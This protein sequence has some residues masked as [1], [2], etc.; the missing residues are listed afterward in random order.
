MVFGQS[1]TFTATVTSSGPAPTGTVTFL[2]G[3]TPIGTSSVSGGIATFSIDT[4]AVGTHAIFAVYNGDSNNN[5]AT[6]LP[7]VVSVTPT[8]TTTTLTASPQ[9]VV[10]G[11]IVTFVATVDAVTPTGGQVAFFD[12]SQVIG[13]APLVNGQATFDQPINGVGVHHV[14]ADYLGTS[15]FLSSA[16]AQAVTVTVLQASTQVILAGQMVRTSQGQILGINLVTT[17]IAAPPGGGVPT[18]FVTYYVN[19]RAFRNLTL[20]NGQ[21]TAFVSYR[22]H[23]N[24]VFVG[25]YHGDANFSGG[26]SNALF[27]NRRFFH[28]AS[29]AAASVTARALRA[30]PV[31]VT[32]PARGKAR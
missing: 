7:A 26:V 22:F 17:V 32:L 29:G 14:T 27:T 31:S 16:S 15:N 13:L 3:S 1:V 4:L 19:G 5:P 23:T 20:I 18:G 10:N 21:A 24:K 11:Q 8:P 25:R 28:P 2:D 9:V 12:G 30:K 6:S